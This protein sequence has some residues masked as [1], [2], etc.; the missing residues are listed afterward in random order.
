MNKQ[1]ELILT[2]DEDDS[3]GH[4]Y[5]EVNEDDTEDTVGHKYRGADE[6]EDDTEGHKYR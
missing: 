4:K 2:L 3:V 5:R 1:D 6:D